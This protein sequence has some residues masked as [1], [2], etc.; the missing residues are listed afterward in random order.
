[1][2]KNN[3]KHKT[4]KRMTCALLVMLLVFL[5]AC[6]GEGGKDKGKDSDSGKPGFGETGGGTGDIY[7]EER[8]EWKV[9]ADV[10]DIEPWS[11]EGKRY[12]S[13]DSGLGHWELTDFTEF[14]PLKD[15][16]EADG[17]SAEV[18]RGGEDE[19]EDLFFDFDSSGRTSEVIVNVGA[20]EDSYLSGAE[21]R[22][23]VTLQYPKEDEE[24]AFWDL[25]GSMYFADI[26][27]DE[28][29]PFGQSVT[30]RDYCYKHPGK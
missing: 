17:Y 28:E 4:T 16:W 10:S 22:P 15:R 11:D 25:Y 19:W 26:E 6:S 8:N 3:K 9:R 1:M 7:P 14:D 12:V 24:N 13:P 27:E 2:K 21:C 20:L 5:S 29:E 18:R 30:M 23:H